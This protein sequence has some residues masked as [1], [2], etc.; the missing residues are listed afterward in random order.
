[1]SATSL[2]RPRAPR[3]RVLITSYLVMN[4]TSGTV[5]GAVLIT[6]P[7]YALSLDASVA[8][9]GLIRGISG[10]GT[11]L[12]VIPA[13][14]LV[15]HYGSK[16]LFVIGGL[17]ATFAT[18]CL[19]SAKT[20]EVLTMVMGLS[21]LFHALKITALNASFFADL[22]SIGIERAGWF[23][24]SMAIGL[25]F[26]GPLLS[27]LMVDVL[28]FA[29]QFELL[30]LLT[31]LPIALVLLFRTEPARSR[32]PRGFTQ[33]IAD[34]L[35]QFRILMAQ[36]TLYLPLMTEGLSSALFAT[37]STFVA[38]VA[39]QLLYLPPAS[40]SLLMGIE[41]ALFIATVFAAAPLIRSLGHRRFY[42]VSTAVIVVGLAIL[43][44]AGSIYALVVAA[45]LL[46]FGLGLTN[47]VVSDRIGRMDGEKGKIV[48]LFSA[49]IGVGLAAGP[50]L[51][52]AIGAV[53]GTPAL[54]LAYVPLFL[55][56]AW[57]ASRRELDLL[58]ICGPAPRLASQRDETAAI[59]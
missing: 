56:L 25:A 44:S 52:G 18:F 24:G 40:A 14:L 54:F 1:M 57:A 50:L 16:R 43:A 26:I 49:A 41:G 21:G 47:L 17:C 4:I 10:L 9:V 45:I 23:K 42:P 12:L 33:G 32:A 51:G 38:V 3:R 5:V 7:L 2:S 13:G 39:V 35:A 29:L 11:L 37:F 8:Q 30:A 34:Q 59:H 58:D 36:R 28:P 48:G 20:P 27:G 31:L 46:G 15:D 19:G 53:L 22:G 6:V 55:L